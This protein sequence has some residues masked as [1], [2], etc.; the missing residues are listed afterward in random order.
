[1][2]LACESILKK[3]NIFYRLIRL[4]AKGITAKDVLNHSPEPVKPEQIC[5]TVVLKRHDGSYFACC[6]LSSRKIDLQKVKGYVGQD[7]FVAPSSEVKKACGYAPG[8]VC[9]VLIDLELYVDKTVFDFSELH[10]GCG[11]VH[12]GLVMDPRDLYK[13][14]PFYAGDISS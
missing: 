12:Y 8:G 14:R 7:A 11:D 13:I 2:V 6:V 9:P 4:E 5:K 3:K 1:M 10:F